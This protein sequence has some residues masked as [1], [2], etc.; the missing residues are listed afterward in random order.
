MSSGS[1]REVASNSHTI[2]SK[3]AHKWA[4]KALSVV[5]ATALCVT[6]C[7]ISA[8]ADDQAKS[9]VSE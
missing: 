7:P 6:M 3:C 9:T 8:Y 1:K 5:L 4:R 2:N